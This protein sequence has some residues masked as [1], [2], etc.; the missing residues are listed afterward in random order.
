MLAVLALGL[1]FGAI[2]AHRHFCTMGALSDYFLFQST[3][4]LRGLVAAT[5]TAMAGTSFLALAGLPVFGDGTVTLPWLAAVLGPLAF[6][7]GMTLSGGCITRN[8]V[9]AGQG[10]LKAGLT[11]VVTSLATLVTTAGILA[12]PAAWLRSWSSTVALPPDLLA[13]AGLLIAAAAAAWI[14][15]PAKQRI[16]A[17]TDIVT[18]AALGALVPLWHVLVQ[19]RPWPVMPSFVLPNADLLAAL[20]AGESGWA[21]ALFAAGTIGGAALMGLVRRSHRFEGFVDGADLKRHVLGAL[22]MGAGGGLIGICSFGMAVSGFAAL[23]PVAIVGTL[24]MAA[25]CRQTLRVLEG[26][27]L[28]SR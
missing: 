2:A 25:G 1:A 18:G 28:F 3:R 26:R 21:G 24:A 7:A 10:S 17:R 22:L 6:G 23:L 16:R 9:R 20:A 4:R 5:A 14:L 19:T 27:G 11:L 12:G 15:V 8:L 13:P